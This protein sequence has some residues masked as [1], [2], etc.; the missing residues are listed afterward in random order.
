MAFKMG[1]FPEDFHYKTDLH[2]K[3]TGENG[4]KKNQKNQSPAGNNSSLTPLK[5][6]TNSFA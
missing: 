4:K 6:L 3:M 5:W 1:L 2:S